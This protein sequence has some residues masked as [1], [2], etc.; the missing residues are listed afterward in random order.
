MFWN[1]QLH[2]QEVGHGQTRPQTQVRSIFAG[3]ARRQCMLG[4]TMQELADY[5]GVARCTIQAW[6]DRYPEFAQAVT[7]GRRETDFDVA[8]RLLDKAKGYEVEVSRLVQ[9]DGEWV[10]RTYTRQM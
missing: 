10:E 4:A 1:S 6:C 5:F 2:C 8:Q 9:V 7:Q 3:H